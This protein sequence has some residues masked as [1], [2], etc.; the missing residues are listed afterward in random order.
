MLGVRMEEERRSAAE[1]GLD[2]ADHLAAG[3]LQQEDALLAIRRR[4]PFPVRREAEGGEATHPRE[5][6]NHLRDLQRVPF[7]QLDPTRSGPRRD[8]TEP[9]PLRGQRGVPD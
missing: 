1:T 4:D 7:A 9:I 8:E 2:L 3:S 5:V 6:L